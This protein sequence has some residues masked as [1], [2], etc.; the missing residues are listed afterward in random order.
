ME[1]EVVEVVELD[2]VDEVDE[3]VEVVA[4]LKISSGSIES[5]GL[6]GFE[7]PPDKRKPL[8]RT[9][10]PK[11]ILGLFICPTSFTKRLVVFMCSI[12]FLTDVTSS[13]VSAPPKT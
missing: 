13:T 7:K 12:V 1:V 10:Q 2:E 11:D 3:V 4:K 8:L 9:S 6:D 5:S